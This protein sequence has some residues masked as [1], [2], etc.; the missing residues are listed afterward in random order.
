R[1]EGLAVVA[2]LERREATLARLPSLQPRLKA[3]LERD[4]DRG[5]AAVA[6][7]DLAVAPL[8]ARSGQQ[9][10]GQRDRG[11]VGEAGEHHVIETRGLALERRD[12]V[13]VTVAVD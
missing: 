1:A 9:L 5:R 12:H 3:E 8:C 10:L 6:V 7:E 4:L 11:L 2:V 13:R